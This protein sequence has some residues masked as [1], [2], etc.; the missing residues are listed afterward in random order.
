V[1]SAGIILNLRQAAALVVRLGRSFAGYAAFGRS[2]LRV[3]L[4]GVRRPICSSQKRQLTGLTA[5]GAKM[6]N[7]WLALTGL[8][9]LV[10]LQVSGAEAA[11]VDFTITIVCPTCLYPTNPPGE[12]ITTPQGGG[13]YLVTSVIAT[14]GGFPVSLAPV[15]T[16]S[17]GSGGFNDN[18]LYYNT[19]TP[20]EYFDT[21]GL[22][23][24]IGGNP[25]DIACGVGCFVIYTDTPSDLHAI[26]SLTVS[27]TPL[28]AALPLFAGGLGGL[29]LFGW[30]RKRKN[31]PAIAA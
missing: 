24:L 21:M 6:R 8:I 13:D 3:P 29:G 1:P 12:L 30:R 9:A 28:P 15:G 25:T 5:E 2:G 14:V 31:A 23:Q 18:I 17:N 20:T 10:S 19:P 27:Q 7:L 4:H 11:S 22:G 26:T 16:V